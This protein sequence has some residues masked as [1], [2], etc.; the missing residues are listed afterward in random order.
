MSLSV[1]RRPATAADAAFAY[2]V[3]EDTMRG[4]AVATWGRWLEREAREAVAADAAAGRSEIVEA[5]GQRIGLLR[6]DR[7]ATHLELEQL[8]LLPAWQRQGIGGRL[9]RGLQDDAQRH[10]L[11]LRLRV[12]RVNPARAFYERLGFRVTSETAERVFM[13]FAG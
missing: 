5:Q 3:L 12:L 8:F 7:F 10:G 13:E 4:H 11:P 9:V 6:L 1:M 2:Q